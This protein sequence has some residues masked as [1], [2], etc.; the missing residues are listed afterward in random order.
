MPAPR[1]PDL[2]RRHSSD[3]RVHKLKLPARRKVGYMDCNCPIWAAGRT[4]TGEIPRQSTGTRDLKTAEAILA[5]LTVTD[6]KKEADGPT[7]EECIQK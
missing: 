3:C 4:A 6:K 7:I 1:T 5:A 2:F